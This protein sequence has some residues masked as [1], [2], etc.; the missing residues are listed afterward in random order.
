MNKLDFLIMQLKAEQKA[1]SIMER[2]QRNFEGAQNANP[3]DIPQDN[4]PGQ[5][6]NPAQPG[7]V[8]GGN[9][10]PGPAEQ[11]VNGG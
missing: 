4:Q 5:L 10:Y 6:D 9:I 1:R 11:P 7:N 3:Q 8:P 2:V